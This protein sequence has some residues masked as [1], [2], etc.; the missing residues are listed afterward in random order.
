MPSIEPLYERLGG[1]EAVARIVF[2]FYDRVLKSTRLAPYFAGVDMRRLI[3]HQTSFL[4]SAMGGPPSYS[5]DHLRQVHARLKVDNPAFDEM[6]DLL[7]ETL[8]AFGVADEDT[9]AVL[10][11]LR[12]RRV[13]IV[14]ASEAPAVLNGES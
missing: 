8:E 4:V 7:G 3:D 10:S 14:S 11:G 9:A 1:I 5:N 13:H 12:A 6:I 2:A